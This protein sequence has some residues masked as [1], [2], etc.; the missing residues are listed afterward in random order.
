MKKK[1][2][3]ILFERILSMHMSQADK[4]GDGQ[5]SL[6]EFYN[7]YEELFISKK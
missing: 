5:I 6:E 1:M 7:I 3:K 4:S 2:G